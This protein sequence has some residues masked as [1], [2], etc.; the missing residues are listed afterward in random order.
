MINSLT[1][2]L[3]SPKLP[4]VKAATYAIF[5]LTQLLLKDSVALDEDSL[6][7]FVVG[8]VQALRSQLLSGSTDM[9]FIRFLVICLGGMVI[10]GE[11]S[12]NSTN[13]KRLLVTLE[14]KEVISKV[15]VEEGKEVLSL[16]EM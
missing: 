5:N 9:E 2:G 6:I 16:L 8:I 15:A 12:N 4:L 14:A 13:V 3:V 1:S 11:R 7:R 10:I